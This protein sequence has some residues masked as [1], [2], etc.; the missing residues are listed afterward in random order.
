MQH[1]IIDAYNL[2]YK[3]RGLKKLIRKSFDIAGQALIVKLAG[4]MRRHPSYNFSVIF[5]GTVEVVNPY[6]SKIK[7]INSGEELTA[8][9]LIKRFVRA[10]TNPHNTIVVSSDVELQKYG[11]LYGLGFVSSAE[12]SKMIEDAPEEFFIREKAEKPH[13]L[14]KS[15]MDDLKEIFSGRKINVDEILRNYSQQTDRKNNADGSFDDEWLKNRLDP[16]NRGKIKKKKKE[17]YDSFSDNE[18]PSNP[19]KKEIEELK[20]LFGKDKH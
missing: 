13:S 6:E 8:D 7:I 18:K 4:L 1:Y 9:D 19:S 2:I 20:K 12:F 10:E 14:S 16:D 15:E 11:R 17:K 3:N 5:D